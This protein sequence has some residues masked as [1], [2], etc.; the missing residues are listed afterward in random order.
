MPDPATPA[1]QRPKRAKKKG[2]TP[3]TI[4]GVLLQIVSTILEA[5]FG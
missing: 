2:E 3:K 5:L 4:L 1:E